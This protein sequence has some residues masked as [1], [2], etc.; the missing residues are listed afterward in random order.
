[1]GTA[2]VKGIGVVDVREAGV[3]GVRIARSKGSSR[4]LKINGKSSNM[5]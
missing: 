5:C 1:M 4:N 3:A 2:G